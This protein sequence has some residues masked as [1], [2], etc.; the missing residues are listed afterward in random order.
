E[1]AVPRR[2]VDL[3]AVQGDGGTVVGEETE[4]QARRLRGCAEA[5][6]IL[7]DIVAPLRAP[8]RIDRDPACAWDGAPARKWRNDRRSDRRGD[9]W[10]AHQ[11]P[12]RRARRDGLVEI[13]ADPAMIAVD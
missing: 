10:A 5:E 9:A 6:R 13:T 3:L 7:I 4:R 2:A 8:R 12:S 11:L 1:I